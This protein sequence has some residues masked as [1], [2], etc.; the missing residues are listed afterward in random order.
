MAKYLVEFKLEVVKYYEENR[1]EYEI[2]AKHFN[3]GFACV[4]R[5]V[6]KYKVHGVKGI[7]KNQE[8]I[9]H[10]IVAQLYFFYFPQHPLNINTITN[11]HSY[12]TSHYNSKYNP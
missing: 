4:Q 3:V 11:H 10:F 1:C 8:Y 6:N 12:N 5:W 7:I 2:T 9:L